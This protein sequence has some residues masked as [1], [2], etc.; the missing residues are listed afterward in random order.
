MT[1]INCDIGERG[2]D[3]P[4]DRELIGLIQ[5]A[6]IACG[7]HAGDRESVS[8]FRQL[9]GQHNVEIAGHLSYPD[10]KNFGRE[11]MVIGEKDLKASLDEQF[12]LIPDIRMIKFHGALYNDSCATQS[13]AETLSDWLVANG[14]TRIITPFDSRLAKQCRPKGVII[15][16][17][18]F[19]E[20]RYTCSKET[21]QLSLVSRKFDYAC[22]HNCDEAVRH[23]L[24]IV[25]RG[26]VNAYFE[27]AE[28]NTEQRLVPI[29]AETI[30]IHSDSTIALELAR[31]LSKAFGA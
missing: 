31:A 28:G 24:D 2:A 23:S 18:A 20:R 21:G 10:R 11:S 25:K 1:K 19:A 6:N 15:V 7:G 29:E 16:P 30:C 9:A 4:I 5:I 3:H 14:I 26:Q 17:E 8:A 22:I 27:T 12:S 13:L